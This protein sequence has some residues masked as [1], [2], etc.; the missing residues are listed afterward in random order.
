VLVAK[1]ASAA[2]VLK[3]TTPIENIPGT[4]IHDTVDNVE[5]NFGTTFGVE[6]KDVVEHMRSEQTQITMGGIE[7]VGDVKKGGSKQNVENMSPLAVLKLDGM[8]AFKNEKLVGFLNSKESR[9]TA[10]TL[11]KVKNT[12]VIV[13]CKKGQVAIEVIHSSA[14]VKGK[15]RQGKPYVVVHVE[16]E[17]NIG[18]TLCPEKDV[19]DKKSINDLERGTDE[20]VKKEILAAVNQAKKW[21]TDIFGFAKAIY[22]AYWKENKYNW[23][24]IFANIPVEVHVDTEIRRE[25]T[26]NRSYFRKIY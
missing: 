22:K 18:E 17:A 3:I 20:Q 15:F 26:R 2:D 10:W 24:G 25:G 16:Q 13:P 11:D 14:T 19:S 23:D 8:A 9:G 6:I 5:K 12:V 4:K 21:R 7:I 1:G